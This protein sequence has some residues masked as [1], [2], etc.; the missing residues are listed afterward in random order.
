MLRSPAILH[1]ATHG[2]FLPSGGK[3]ENPLVRSGLILAG[4]NLQNAS[5]NNGEDGVL[6]ALEVSGLDLRGTKLVV[7]SAC[8]TGRGD[9]ANGE[10]VYGLRRAFTLSGAESQL[11]SLWSVDDWATQALLTRYYDYVLKGKGRSEAWRQTQLDMLQGRLN[12]AIDPKGKETITSLA[13]PNYWGAFVPSGDWTAI[14]G[15]RS[16]ENNL[17]PVTPSQP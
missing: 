12:S 3:D 10:G 15:D 9:V 5:K 4:A 7:M 17:A 2:F 13:H 14:R 8:D 11:F 6:T 16:G 1:F